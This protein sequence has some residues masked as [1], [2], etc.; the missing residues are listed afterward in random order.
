M[1]VQ[2][3]FLDSGY[4][5]PAWEVDTLFL[6][7]FNPLCGEQLDYYY[8]RRSNGFWKIIKHFDSLNEFDFSNFQELKEFMTLKK[9]G[10]VDVIRCVTF[11]EVDRNEI[12]GNGYT[13]DN[14]F[15][16][17]NYSREYNF[18]QI[19]RFISEQ[20]ITNIFTTWG[21]RDKPKEFRTLV[22][23]FEIF[24]SNNQSNFNK[25]KSPSGRLYKGEEINRIHSNW[26]LYLNPILG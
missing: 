20:N 25:L 3:Q 5:F 2:H 7:T 8:R 17:K 16:V 22:T 9:F 13:D 12:C 10:C 15:K 19:K 11:P 14:L 23:D 24:C 1:T 6:G 4:F 18:E 21:N 26:F